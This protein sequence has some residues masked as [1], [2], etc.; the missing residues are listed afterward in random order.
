M[1]YFLKVRHGVFLPHLSFI[2]HYR[3]TIPYST[4]WRKLTARGVKSIVLVYIIIIY[5]YV[6]SV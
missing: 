5:V 2:I 6:S 1:G 3:V 4:V